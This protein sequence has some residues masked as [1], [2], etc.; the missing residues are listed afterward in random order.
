MAPH[1]RHTT[2]IREDIEKVSQLEIF[3]SSDTAGVYIVE[4]RSGRQVFVMGHSELTQKNIWDI[5]V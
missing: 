1:S 4:A 2:V 3:A 5:L